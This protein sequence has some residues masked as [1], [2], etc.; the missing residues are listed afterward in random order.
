VDVQDDLRTRISG[1]TDLKQLNVWLR[2][3]AVA[4]AAEDLFDLPDAA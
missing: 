1:C 3:A 2:R 4:G